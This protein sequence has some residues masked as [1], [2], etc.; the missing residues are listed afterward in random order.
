MVKLYTTKQSCY[1]L[2]F[3]GD[4]LVKKSHQKTQNKTTSPYNLWGGGFL[5]VFADG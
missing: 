5:W 1:V 2:V 3:V 4:F